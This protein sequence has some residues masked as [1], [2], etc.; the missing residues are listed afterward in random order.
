VLLDCFIYCVSLTLLFGDSCRRTS[1]LQR[2]IFFFFFNEDSVVGDGLCLCLRG[3]NAL[4]RKASV[5]SV[6][7]L[8]LKLN[9]ENH[10]RGVSSRRPISSEGNNDG[11]TAV[12][13]SW[14][15]A[16]LISWET[17]PSEII[18]ATKLACSARCASLPFDAC[19]SDVHHH[20]KL[21]QKAS[22][23][24]ISPDVLDW[25]TW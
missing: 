16:K 8:Q 4:T 7:E 3:V 20:P 25:I 21:L 11:V 6:E 10:V 24:T 14:A 5:W 12:L 9:L 1:R 17:V 19:D 13:S 23:Q 2:S 22:K 15:L 18:R